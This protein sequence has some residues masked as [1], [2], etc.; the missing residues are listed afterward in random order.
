M[1]PWLGEPVVSRLVGG[2][3]GAA[4]PARLGHRDPGRPLDHAHIVLPGAPLVKHGPYRFVNHPNYLVVIGE[5]AVLPLGLGLP[6][7]ALVFSIANLAVLGIRVRAET[8]T[9]ER[10]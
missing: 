8:A 3:P 1:G 9:F 10:L 4:D 7:Y 5:I 2:V 6:W